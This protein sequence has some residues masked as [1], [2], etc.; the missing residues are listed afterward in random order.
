[1]VY[2]MKPKILILIVF[3][4]IAVSFLFLKTKK[5]ETIIS[6]QKPTPNTTL[7][8]TISLEKTK[9]N[10]YQP[11]IKLTLKKPLGKKLEKSLKIQFKIPKEFA[12]ST[13]ELSFSIP[14][15]EILEKDPLI[16]W[17]FD[18]KDE[19]CAGIEKGELCEIY[20]YYDG[21]E[22]SQ[23]KCRK[24][25]PAEKEKLRKERLCSI[26]LGEAK[27]MIAQWVSGLI[28]E[29]KIV[30][31]KKAVSYTEGLKTYTETVT[32]LS[33]QQAAKLTPMPTAKLESG[34]V[35][36]GDKL[37]LDKSESC[38]SYLTAGDKLLYSPTGKYFLVDYG[39]FEGD[40]DLFLFNADGSGKKKI[41]EKFDWLNYGMVKWEPDGK[42]FIYDRTN[43]CC[44]E[45]PP[46]APK[47]GKVKYDIETG[48]KTWLSP[49]GYP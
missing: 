28:S 48:T 3:I 31:T 7:T 9:D 8:E 26:T 29:L 2:Q 30:I 39:C 18:E 24:L 49:L 32:Q 36:L 23:E 13:D 25:D 46:S 33:A 15:S 5:H 21:N 41:T 27:D 10:L 17:G 20:V 6:T 34:K 44:L 37:L 42:S 35:Y 11:T 1:M 40:D 43:G 4:A 45:A 38:S 22:P 19:S 47:P 14:P 16:V 12:A